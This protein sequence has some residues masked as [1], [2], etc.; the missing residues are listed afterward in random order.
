ME[1]RRTQIDYSDRW[2]FLFAGAKLA[3]EIVTINLKTYR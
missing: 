3:A 2:E 1:I